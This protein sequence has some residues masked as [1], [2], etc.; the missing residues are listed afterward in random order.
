MQYLNIHPATRLPQGLRA[1]PVRYW[2]LAALIILALLELSSAQL[3][4]LVLALALGFSLVERVN[5]LTHAKPA[6]PASSTPN[7]S[8]DGG[9]FALEPTATQPRDGVRVV[10]DGGSFERSHLK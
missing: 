8:F 9:T 4:L 7:R 10:C 6:P 2:L 5:K 1:I 3:I